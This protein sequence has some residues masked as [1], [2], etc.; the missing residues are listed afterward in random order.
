[1]LGT[2]PGY[3]GCIPAAINN[4]TEVVGAV[5]GVN[6][7]DPRTNFYWSPT[8]SMV[9]VIADQVTEFHDINDAGIICGGSRAGTVPP[10]GILT[11][12]IRTGTPADLGMLPGSELNFGYSINELGQVA[13]VCIDIGISGFRTPNPIV[14]DPSPLVQDLGVPH[15]TA[16]GINERG[17]VVGWRPFGSNN[18]YYTWLYSAQFGLI[19]DIRTLIAD[20]ASFPYISDVRAINDRGQII[21]SGSNSHVPADSSRRAFILSP[22]V[23][24]AAD[25]TGDSAATVPDIFAFL[26][27]WFANDAAADFDGNGAIAVP[28]IF[29]FLSAWF[30]G[31]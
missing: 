20:A 16:R 1:M 12:D 28:D 15:A 23:A 21:A 31:C 8:T 7:A 11:F 10:P 5:T 24:C 6:P 25:F 30:G 3:D 19:T 4:H 26:S 14:A 13:G 22:V 17:D 18:S 2:M 27:L 9:R 29:T